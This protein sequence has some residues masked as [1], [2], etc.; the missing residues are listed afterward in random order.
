MACLQCGREKETGESAWVT[1]LGSATSQRTCYCPECFRELVRAGRHDDAAA[2]DGDS[3]L[4]WQEVGA[5]SALEWDLG[6]CPR[7]R[8]R[9]SPVA[10]E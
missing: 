10:G 8:E 9:F 4:Q 1:V 6:S 5:E 3:I 2:N 7:R